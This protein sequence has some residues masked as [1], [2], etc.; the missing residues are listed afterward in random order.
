MLVFSDAQMSQWLADTVYPF[1]RIAAVFS[2]APVFSLRQ[3]PIRARVLL[4]LLITWLLQPLI[5]AAPVFET[6]GPEAFL[7]AMQQVA[8]GLSI[9]FLMQMVF[10]A[11]IFGGQVIAFSMGLGFAFM[12]DPQNGVQVPVVSQF[13]L[14]LATLAF[15]VGNGHLVL[16]GVLAD[17][18]TA[19][20]VGIEGLDRQ[21]LYNIAAWGSE[22]FAAGVLMGL[23]VIIALLLANIG[24]G[25]VSRAA[26]QLN[27]F[28]VGFP[29]TLLMGLVLMWITVPQVLASF[30]ELITGVL[31]QAL[32]LIG[33]EQ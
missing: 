14:L 18:F 2:A 19:M 9:G 32:D 3:F 26:P 31:G 24:L 22:L 27:I 10:Q 13:Y 29:V 16:L 21:G 25:V 11:L 5:P 7:V 12:M 6:F 33:G 23:P 28:A 30:G 8:I 20:P 15:V 1:M 17:S 4:A